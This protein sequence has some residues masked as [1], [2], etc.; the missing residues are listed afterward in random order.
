MFPAVS[1]ALTSNVC[2]CP[3]SRL[4]NL[5]VAGVSLA[6]V[7]NELASKLHSKLAIGLVPGVAVTRNVMDV[8]TVEPP[9][10]IGFP[11]PSV[12]DVLLYFSER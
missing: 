7:E 12:A 1:T 8:E 3:A 4:L 2:L 6:Q 9:S 10:F 5:I 11:I